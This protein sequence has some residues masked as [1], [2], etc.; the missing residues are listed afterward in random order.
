LEADPI[1]FSSPYIF[2][3]ATCVI[4]SCLDAPASLAVFSS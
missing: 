3:D 1:F 4:L 2:Y